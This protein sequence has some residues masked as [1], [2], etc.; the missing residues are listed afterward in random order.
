[1]PQS[2]YF[3]RTRKLAL[4]ADGVHLYGEYRS[5][6]GDISFQGGAVSPLVR[7]EE[8]EAAVFGMQL[9]G[10]LTPK[11]SYV[12]RVNYELDGGRIRLAVSATQLNMGYSPGVGDRFS[13]GAIRFTPLVFSAQYNAER[14][15]LTS[16]YALR[17]LKY[18]FLTGPNLSFTGESYYFQ[19]VYR[20][21][22]QWEGIV[23]YDVLYTDR[24]DRNGEEWAATHPYPKNPPAHSRFAKDITVGLRWNITP[25]FMLRAEYHRVNGTGWLSTLDNTDNTQFTQHWDLFS[26]L[27]SFRF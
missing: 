5:E 2:I 6:L 18:D 21:T 10:D 17:H 9:P 8:A 24:S 12:S 13:E 11:M 7:G 1:L 26:I 20:F 22:P 14:W 25:E 19:G 4:A 27:G 23:R 15:S 16:E 3:D